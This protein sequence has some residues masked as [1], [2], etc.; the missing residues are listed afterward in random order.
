[1]TMLPLSPEKLIEELTELARTK[2]AN[3]LPNAPEDH[4]LEADAA[5]F[6]NSAVIFLTD[7]VADGGQSAER[8]LRILDRL[9]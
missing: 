3:P 4:T 9:E 5:A 1:M 2:S 6:I 8:A 7:L